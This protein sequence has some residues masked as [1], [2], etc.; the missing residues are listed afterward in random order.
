MPK[1]DT[2]IYRNDNLPPN[3]AWGDSSLKQTLV[4]TGIA[5]AKSISAEFGHAIALLADGTIKA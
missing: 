2:S 1:Q 4:P 5:T 3:L